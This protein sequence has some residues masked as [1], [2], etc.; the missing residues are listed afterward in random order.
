M[1]TIYVCVCAFVCSLTRGRKPVLL[2]HVEYDV[3]FIM[4]VAVLL[5][6]MHGI[7]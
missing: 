4:I 6:D 7:H 3:C 2:L 1:G 5:L